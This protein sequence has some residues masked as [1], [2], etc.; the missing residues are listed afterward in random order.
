M[1]LGLVILG[2][3]TMVALAPQL[4]AA[5]PPSCGKDGSGNPIYTSIDFGS[6]SKLCTGQGASPV[7]AILLWV[8]NFLAV[9]VGVAV[10]IG[11]IFGGITYAMSDGDSGKAKQGMEIIANAIIGLFLFL[12]MYAAANFM[13]P[14]GL[15]T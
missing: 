9:G 15:F 4:A 3:A 8:I 2:A 1:L 10:V 11:I 5:A 13:V 12:F 6:T 14:G 7:T